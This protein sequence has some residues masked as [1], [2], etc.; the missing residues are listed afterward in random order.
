[1]AATPHKAK[2]CHEMALRILL[3]CIEV[4]L[5]L[6]T[7]RPPCPVQAHERVTARPAPV[8]TVGHALTLLCWCSGGVP[9]DASSA[10]AGAA[11]SCAT[12]TS[13]TSSLCCQFLWTSAFESLSVS[14]REYLA[15]SAPFLPPVMPL[16]L[17][18]AF[19]SG[20]G[21]CLWYRAV[22]LVQGCVSGTGLCLW[23]RPPHWPTTSC[24]PEQV[25][26][27]EPVCCCPAG[28]RWQ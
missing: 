4:L 19:V 21:L 12:G 9:S 16:S 18:Q 10:R 8:R 17:I 20:T 28:P 2:Y 27:P 3:A 24:A 22:S 15:P 5:R 13:A 1:M 11:G 23:Y 25:C 14:T 6:P 7:Q 26:F